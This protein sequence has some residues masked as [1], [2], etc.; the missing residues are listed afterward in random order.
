MERRVGRAGARSPSL[1]RSSRWLA[2]PAAAS[3]ASI[4]STSASP[5]AWIVLGATGPA[6]C[7]PGSGGDTP[8]RRPGRGRARAGRRVGPAAGRARRGRPDSGRRPAGPTS[9]DRRLA[10]RRRTVRGRPCSSP[11][12]RSPAGSRSV[13]DGDRLGE[14]VVELVDHRSDRRLGLRRSRPRAPPGRWPRGWS[15]YGPIARQRATIRSPSSRRLDRAGT[16]ARLRKRDLGP[17]ERVD[18]PLGRPPA[19]VDGRAPSRGTRCSAARVTAIRR[20]ELG[21]RQTARVRS[22]RSARRRPLR[23]ARRRSDVREPVVEPA[24]AERGRE[25]SGRARRAPSQA[26]SASPRRARRGRR[27]R[28]LGSAPRRSSRARA[29]R[30]LRGRADRRP[31]PARRRRPAR[32]RTRPTGR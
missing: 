7:A 30:R 27:R 18:R 4:R 2:R 28:E 29:G 1:G 26:S 17:F 11:A 16:T 25:Q 10:A 19:V 5:I 14:Q 9:A 23:R 8:R 20:R 15:T 6:R 13:Q 12:A 31:D 22:S 21:L 3:S 32:A 24:V